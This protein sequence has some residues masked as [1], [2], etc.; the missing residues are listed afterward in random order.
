MISVSHSNSSAKPVFNVADNSYLF[1]FPCDKYNVCS[2]FEIEFKR[3]VYFLE[4]WGASGGSKISSSTAKGG[5]GGHSSG[6]FI[7]LRRKR[8]FLHIGGHTDQYGYG[9]LGSPY[10]GGG[11]SV[12]YN[13]ATGGGATDFRTKKGAW[14]SNL[15]SR[16]LVSGAGGGGR[17]D[18]GIQVGGD[19]GG[20][21]G[22]A[23]MGSKCSSP[24]GGQKASFPSV[25]ENCQN[26]LG[27]FGNGASGFGGGGGGYWGGGNSYGS[28]GG[29]G[30]GFVSP[31]L[32]SVGDYK[33]LT[34]KSD[35]EGFGRAKITI[36]SEYLP[37]ELMNKTCLIKRFVNPR[38]MFFYLAFTFS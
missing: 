34:E 27:S 3:G 4:C 31:I 17:I 18:G 23:G 16:I 33:A 36:L 35:N 11:T 6:V 12:N 22:S 9:A 8:L 5:K 14:N 26:Y 32:F 37:S 1:N 24:F 29:G 30:S 21:N 10:N 28:A 19:G 25:T 7:V 2:A 38:F 15:E 13:D 20:I